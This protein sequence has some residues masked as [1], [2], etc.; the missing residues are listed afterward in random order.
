MA[1]AAERSSVL[2][3]LDEWLWLPMAL[4][5]PAW[6]LILIGELLWG[7][8]TLL[9]LTS[10]AVWVIFIAELALRLILAP[11]RSSFFQPN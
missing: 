4:L 3:E 8:N 6:L 9:S 2:E 11:D 7:E 5:G 1:S 10:R